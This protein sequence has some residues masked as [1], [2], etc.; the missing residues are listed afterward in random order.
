MRT[1]PDRKTTVGSEEDSEWCKEYWRNTIAKRGPV[2]ASKPAERVG[3][4]VEREIPAVRAMKSWKMFRSGYQSPILQ[5]C[6][7]RRREAWK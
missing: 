7:E 5:G 4:S 1:I 6:E 3:S 2:H